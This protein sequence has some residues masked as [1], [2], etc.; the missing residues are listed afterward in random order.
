MEV[1]VS[2][3]IL[4]DSSVVVSGFSREEHVFLA[5]VKEEGAKLLEK[6][7]KESPA[8]SL[9]IHLKK[10]IHGRGKLFEIKATARMKRGSLHASSSARDV[11][12]A[13]RRAFNELSGQ[14]ARISGYKSGI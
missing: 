13:L 4:D 5:S 12:L 1:P 8:E 14:A 7:R 3:N 2:G 11:Y 9:E 10:A 6:L